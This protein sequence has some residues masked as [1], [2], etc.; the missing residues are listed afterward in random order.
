[1]NLA[2]EAQ[3]TCQ[4]QAGKEKLKQRRR[5]KKVHG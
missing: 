3:Q 2:R 1:M 4:R 5:A